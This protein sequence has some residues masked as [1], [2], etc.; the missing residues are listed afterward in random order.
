MLLDR[1]L[2]DHFLQ[3]TVS[4]AC[5]FLN[6]CLIRPI[7]KKTPYEL[8]RGKKSYIS[9]F[10]PFGCKCFIHNNGKNNLGKYD[11]RSDKVF[12]DTNPRVQEIEGGD[13][14]ITSL[15]PTEEISKVTL[16]PNTDESAIAEVELT[17]LADKA[18]IPR[19]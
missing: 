3:E 15:K 1:N 16:E 7:L 5:H 13:D 11:P 2:P 17:T 19:E 8:W 12:D 18:N 14:E 10:H 4:T 6:K 9:Y